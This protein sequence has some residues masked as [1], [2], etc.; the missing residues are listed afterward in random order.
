MLVSGLLAS[1]PSI[2]FRPLS[3]QRSVLCRLKDGHSLSL[4]RVPKK[5]RH[6]LQISP[7]HRNIGFVDFCR[8]RP[9]QVSVGS[10]ESTSAAVASAAVEATYAYTLTIG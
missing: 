4:Q 7:D 2:G 8:R 10:G 5:G 9:Y 1:R 6:V 3:N